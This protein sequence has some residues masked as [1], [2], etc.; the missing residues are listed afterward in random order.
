MLLVNSLNLD[1][2]QPR[3]FGFPTTAQN[4]QKETYLTKLYRLNEK[5]KT[6]GA[7]ISMYQNPSNSPIVLLVVSPKIT[8]TPHQM[9]P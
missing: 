1:N 4:N 7:K 9:Y 6:K 8:S 5:E 2:F 3:V